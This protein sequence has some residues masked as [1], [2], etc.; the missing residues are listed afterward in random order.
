MCPESLL[1]D[2][3]YY[4]DPIEAY[5]L[6]VNTNSLGEIDHS[7]L[8][9]RDLIVQFK[10]I[11]AKTLSGHFIIQVGSTPSWMFSFNLGK[12][13]WISGGIDPITRWQ[14]NLDIA[15]LHLSLNLP[16]EIGNRNNLLLKSHLLAQQLLAAETLF[17]IIQLC[18]QPNHRLSYQLISI[19]PDNIKL[20]PNLPLLDI[21]PI[22]TTAIQSWQAWQTAGLAEYF[23]S[24]FLNIHQSEQLSAVINIDNLLELLLSIDGNRSLRNLA[25]YHRQNLLDFTKVLLPLLKSGTISLS[26]TQIDQ[27]ETTNIDSNIAHNQTGSLIACIDD[28]ILVYKNLEKFLTK[29]G[30]RSYSVQDPLKVIPTLIKNKPSLIFLDLLMPIS[31]GY[32]VCEQIRKTPSL[33]DIPVVILT[34]KDGLFDR[35]R[36]KNIGANEFLRKPIAHADVLMVLRK[37]VDL[38]V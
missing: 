18:Q 26:P 23:P 11:K 4:L 2:R 24:Q 5:L 17:D 12:L 8:S 6:L 3:L 38:V 37:Y 9:F 14:R 7:D 34:A 16:S 31:N 29:Q 27:T 33:K 13:S 30:Y 32:E 22:L 20:N 1:L 25:I 15:N 10:D 36:A 19:D 28:S 21:Q 35:L